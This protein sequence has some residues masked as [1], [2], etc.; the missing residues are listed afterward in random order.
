MTPTG[1]Y[2]QY[3]CNMLIRREYRTLLLPTKQD[4]L[5]VNAIIRLPR[6][7][8]QLLKPGRPEYH[9]YWILLDFLYSLS[10]FFIRIKNDFDQKNIF[11]W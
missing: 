4:K 2:N 3:T 7:V 1:E 10:I 11:I 9:K 5:L 6:I 8:D